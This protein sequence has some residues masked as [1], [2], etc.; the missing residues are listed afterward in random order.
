M[1]VIV[2]LVS[3]WCVCELPLLISFFK[4]NVGASIILSVFYVCVHY[5]TV[6]ILFMYNWTEPVKSLDTLSHSCVQTFDWYCIYNTQ[7]INRIYKQMFCNDYSNVVIKHLLCDKE[8]GG[9]V[10]DWMRMIH[11]S[12]I[13]CILYS[14]YCCI[15][16]T[17]DFV[18]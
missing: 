15:I 12:C 13:V 11:L 3:T 1:F 17:N 14:K 16:F 18:F 5:K 7:Y 2:I 9:R 4:I 6:A 8:N 10:N